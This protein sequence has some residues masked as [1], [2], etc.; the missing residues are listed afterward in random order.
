MHCKY[1]DNFHG[2]F[3]NFFGTVSQIIPMG[4]KNISTNFESTILPLGHPLRFELEVEQASG[5]PKRRAPS[6]YR[7]CDENRD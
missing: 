7:F 5:C 4:F 6:S 1:C 2:S 3:A